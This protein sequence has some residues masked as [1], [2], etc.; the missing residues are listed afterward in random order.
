MKGRILIVD[1][2]ESLRYTFQKFLRDEG[3]LVETAS[4]FDEGVGKLDAHAFD[5]I[6]ADI[7]IGE[8]SG[9]D[10]LREVASRGMNCPVVMITGYPNVETASEAVRLG[11]FDYLPKPV[12]YDTILHVT[13]TALKH[14]QLIDEREEYRA[15]LESIFRSVR[16]AIV[17]VDRDMTVIEAND[18]VAGVCGYSRAEALGR[19]LRDLASGCSGQCVDAVVRTIGSGDPAEIGR[20]ECFRKGRTQIVTITVM[21][22]ERSGGPDGAVMVIRDETRIVEL[23][24]SSAERSGLHNIVGQSE[25]MQR[26]YGLIDTLADVDTTVLITGESGTGKELVADALHYRGTRR[27]RPLV[28]VNCSALSE[29]LLE[30]ELFGHVR[31]AFTGAVRD[32]IG[33]FE[34]ADG[35]TIFLD[36]IGDVSPAVQAKLLR[37]LQEKTIERVGDNRPRRV[38][39]RI[40]AATNKD[41]QQKVK[42][43]GFREDLYYRLKVVAIALPPLRQRTEDIPLLTAHFIALFNRKFSRQVKA[44][45]GDV[46]RT[47]LRCP[48]GGNV[49]ELEHVLEHAF[50]LC[51]NEIITMEHLPPECCSAPPADGPG[52]DQAGEKARI[53]GAIEKAGGNKAKAARLL[54][55]G[56][57]TLY[58]K[59]EE[60]GMAV[61]GFGE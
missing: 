52:E 6:F 56:R 2:E 51:R 25:A 4:S 38:D 3:H 13:T 7:L 49:R 26:L 40:I 34:M 33:R 45:S 17:T 30:S 43:G 42:A 54:G 35:G 27:D 5:L 22:L 41:L 61:D 29:S 50:I 20:L 15:K 46:M 21:P 14:K 1:D 10:F 31:G 59:L 24:R 8:R 28:K 39:V 19:P 48:W 60:L 37:A 11:A 44:V 47:F 36:E 23:E 32:K 58:R 57:R 55:I 9:I 53:L 18:A 12:L 16:D